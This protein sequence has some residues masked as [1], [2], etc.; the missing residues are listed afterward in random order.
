MLKKNPNPG[1]LKT[2]YP[3]NQGLKQ[4][5]VETGKVAEAQLKTPYPPNQGLK[6][7]HAWVQKQK[8]ALL[9]PLIHQTKD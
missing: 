8:L 6:Q 1:T 2:P 9:K 7:I 4:N 5:F 3:P